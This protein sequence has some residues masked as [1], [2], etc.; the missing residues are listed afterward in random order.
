VLKPYLKTFFG[1]RCRFTPT[2]S[3]YAYEAIKRYGVI[4]GIPLSIKR[5]VKCNPMSISV[6]DPVS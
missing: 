2:C 4:K 3:E 5:I 1:G 6:F